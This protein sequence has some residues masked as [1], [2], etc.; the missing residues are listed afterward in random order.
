M[1][2]IAVPVSQTIKGAV[3]GECLALKSEWIDHVIQ[4]LNIEGIILEKPVE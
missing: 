3:A 4:K 2:M 1:S